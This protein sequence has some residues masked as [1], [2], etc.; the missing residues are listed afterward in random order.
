MGTT[1]TTSS[2]S[3]GDLAR[4][5]TLPKKGT[6]SRDTEVKTIKDTS[7]IET[8][9]TP[10]TMTTEKPKDE[11]T[12]TLSVIEPSIDPSIEPSVEPSTVVEEKSSDS[13]NGDPKSA[14]LAAIKMKRRASAI[15]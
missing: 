14:L 5:V 13:N 1:L 4:S 10:L 9:T 2:S 15:L 8:E 11:A 3:D 12:L 7:A 6:E